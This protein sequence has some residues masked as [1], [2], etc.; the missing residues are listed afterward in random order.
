MTADEQEWALQC[1]RATDALC[2][3]IDSNNR[4]PQVYRSMAIRLI[5]FAVERLKPLD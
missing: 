3:A 4:L 2:L 1:Q 5:R